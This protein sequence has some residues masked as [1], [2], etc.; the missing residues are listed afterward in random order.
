MVNSNL[1]LKEPKKTQ[2]FI[3]RVIAFEMDET[4]ALKLSEH[5]HKIYTV[6]KYAHDLLLDGFHDSEAVVRLKVKF[7]DIGKSTLFNHIKIAR[8]AFSFKNSIDVET[9]RYIWLQQNKKLYKLI[10]E[11]HPQVA[12]KL[13][14]QRAKYLKFD[15]DNQ[16]LDPDQ[17]GNHKYYMVIGNKQ[18]NILHAE[19]LTEQ[20]RKEIVD[21]LDI[22][23]IEEESK[24]LTEHVTKRSGG[25]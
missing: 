11:T 9:E 6:I 18:V 10:C 14:G 7:P 25:N 16:M 4:G 21:T 2:T 1:P 12:E 24:L 3:D 5:D 17:Y 15:Q 19:K 20:E 23:F 13:L 22:T 8:Q